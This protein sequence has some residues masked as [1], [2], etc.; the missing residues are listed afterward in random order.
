M[1]GLVAIINRIKRAALGSNLV[2]EVRLIK[3]E[4]DISDI[5]R[6]SVFRAVYITIDSAVIISDDDGYTISLSIVDKAGSYSDDAFIY[7]IDEGITLLRVIAD[8]LNYNAGN[9]N[10]QITYNNIDIRSGLSEGGLITW[11]DATMTYSVT[12]LPNIAINA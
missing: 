7:S 11:I 12:T 8:T 1:N 10:V 6:D 4:E 5:S 9:S 3:S 2:N